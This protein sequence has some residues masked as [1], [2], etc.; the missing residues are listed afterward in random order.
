MKMK[1]TVLQRICLAALWICTI[2]DA[3]SSTIY[4]DNDAGRFYG[5]YYGVIESLQYIAQHVPD[6][7]EEARSA[8]AEFISHMAPYETIINN[9]MHSKYGRRW[10]DEKR[11]LRVQARIE[12][13]REYDRIRPRHALEPFKRAYSFSVGYRHGEYTEAATPVMNKLGVTP[14]KSAVAVTGLPE[15]SGGGLGDTVDGGEESYT[16]I[17]DVSEYLR[18]H[19]L[20]NI[21]EVI[22][23]GDEFTIVMPSRTNR[24][25]ERVG[26]TDT[27]RYESRIP[28]SNAPHDDIYM[29]VEIIPIDEPEKGLLIARL[30]YH[31]REPFERDGFRMEE[32]TQRETRMGVIAEAS[33]TGRIHGRAAAL[34]VKWIVGDNVM[35][36]MM[37]LEP[38][39]NYPSAR[40]ILFLHSAKRSAQSL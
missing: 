40:G 35:A 22:R 25:V 32:Y 39:T 37:V 29:R 23:V 21:H 16:V 4:S 7:S 31:M 1:L 11:S 10:I 8:V 18:Q 24:R 26:L 33:G 5:Y 38:Q 9:S 30:D 13:Q 17:S 27:I 14:L 36:S 34:R 6:L 19:G 12:I 2:V 28:P 15:T 3:H 20:P